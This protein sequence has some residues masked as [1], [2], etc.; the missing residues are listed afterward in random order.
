MTTFDF[1]RFRRTVPYIHAHRGRRVVLCLDS[2]ALEVSDAD[3]LLSDIAQLHALGVQVVL[4]F[5]IRS[6]LD[7]VLSRSHFHEGCRVTPVSDMPKVAAEAGTVYAENSGAA[8][9][10]TD[11]HADGRD[12]VAGVGWE[13]GGGAATRCAQRSGF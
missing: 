12:A 3:L 11:E 4:V 5:G 10:W 6:R 2:M 1:E 8:V 7:R 13:S 9:L